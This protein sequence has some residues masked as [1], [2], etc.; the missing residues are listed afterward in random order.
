MNK[1]NTGLIKRELGSA[2]SEIM[3]INKWWDVSLKDVSLGWDGKKIE[4]TD[5]I[6][7]TQVRVLN[8]SFMVT[9]LYKYDVKIMD[10]CATPILVKFEVIKG[11]L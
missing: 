11:D 1:Y 5:I 6:A 8:L 4:N 9:L 7:T 3:A 10:Y 2:T